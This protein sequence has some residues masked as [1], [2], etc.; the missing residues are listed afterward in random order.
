[1][2]KKRSTIVRHEVSAEDQQAIRDRAIE[3]VRAD[4]EDAQ[5]I[6]AADQ[7]GIADVVRVAMMIQKERRRLP[8]N[9]SKRPEAGD[10]AEVAPK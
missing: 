1:M 2:T 9:I 7:A 3:R 4:L 10:P 8:R 6:L 5:E